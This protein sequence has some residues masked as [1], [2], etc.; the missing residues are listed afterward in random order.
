MMEA[1]LDERTDSSLHLSSVSPTHRDSGQ[2]PFG[3][4]GYHDGH[5]EDHG[6]QEC[7]ANAHGHHEKR[8]AEEDGQACNDV[9]KVFDFNSDGRL[10]IFYS[11]GQGRNAPDDGAVTR[12]HH[13]ALCC[14]CIGAKKAPQGWA[15]GSGDVHAM[16]TEGGRQ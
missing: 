15:G 4:I 11:R 1:I 13:Q 9:H 16:G 5:E 14:A 6:P 2:Q 12:V 7:V 3:H 10:L 8:G